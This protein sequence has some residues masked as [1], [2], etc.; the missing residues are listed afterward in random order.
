M[1]YQSY[2]SLGR[3][4]DGV[5]KLPS[6]WGGY[7]MS[8]RDL[9]ERPNPYRLP[10]ASS[11]SWR[12]RALNIGRGGVVSYAINATYGTL[13]MFFKKTNMYMVWDRLSWGV[14]V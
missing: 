9:S 8:R 3:V 1:S 13:S 7:A 11:W 10:P 14:R 6:F 2:P 12:N 5:Q 4:P